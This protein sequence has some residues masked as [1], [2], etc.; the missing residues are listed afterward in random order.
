MSKDHLL[1]FKNWYI[2][3]GHLKSGLHKFYIFTLSSGVR[4]GVERDRKLAEVWKQDGN[5][6]SQIV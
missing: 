4:F 3:N 5:T 6:Y 2:N 1:E